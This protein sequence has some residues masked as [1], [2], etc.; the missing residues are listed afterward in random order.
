MTAPSRRRVDVEPPAR[1]GALRR[2]FNALFLL[3]YGAWGLVDAFHGQPILGSLAALVLFELS[4]A[5]YRVATFTGR[6][7][8]DPDA[9][10]RVTPILVELCRRAGAELPRLVL[11]DDCLRAAAVRRRKGKVLLILSRP[12]LERIGDPELRALLAHEV[13]HIAR[14]DL[15]PAR[16]RA[17]AS[18]LGGGVLVMIIVV[19]FAH[20]WKDV[21]IWTAAGFVGTLGSSAALSPL[22]RAIE[23]RADAE[24]AALA[25]DP[26][27]LIRA[28]HTADAMSRHTRH[29]I[30][31]RPPW[32]WL[33]SPLSWR[34]P[35]HPPMATRIARLGTPDR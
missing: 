10:A 33:L 1:R 29:Q 27:A 2:H 4:L 28:L 21:P 34:L 17:L 13:I 5:N 23:L 32:R 31:G 26:H 8:S 9:A 11:R 35:T 19:L 22:N 15:R 25:R 14:R 16:A 18:A 6:I 3:G 12:Y 20:Q 30:Y 24:G 7:I